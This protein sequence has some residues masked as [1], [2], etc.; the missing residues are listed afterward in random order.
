[1][2]LTEVTLAYSVITALCGFLSLLCLAGIYSY[3]TGVNLEFLLTISL[4]L[5]IVWIIA[6]FLSWIIVKSYKLLSLMTFLLALIEI[7][8]GGFL[9]ALP[10]DGSIK[11]W[12]ILFSIECFVCS[13]P[14][15]LLLQFIIVPRLFDFLKRFK[16]PQ[17]IPEKRL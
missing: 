14:A 16:S 3:S 5:I 10:S 12:I 13:I 6:G 17:N 1:M 7:I 11:G 15:Y 9:L 2:K 8:L 4:P